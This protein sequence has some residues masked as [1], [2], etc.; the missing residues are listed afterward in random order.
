[1]NSSY[2]SNIIQRMGGERGFDFLVT[3]YSEN[4]HDDASLDQ[5]FGKFDLNTLTCIQKEL[6]LMSFLEPCEETWP[7]K[8]RAMLRNDRM[9]LDRSIFPVLEE[10]F[11]DAL[12]DCFIEGLDFELCKAYFSE[13]HI[14]FKECGAVSKYRDNLIERMGGEAAFEFLVLSYCERLEDD[15][16]LHRYFKDLKLQR[17]TLLHKELILMAVLRPNAENDFEALA[18]RVA[19]TFSPLFALGM[20]EGHFE[21]MESHFSAAVYECLSQADVIQSCLRLFSNLVTFFQ[22]NSLLGNSDN[23][24]NDDEEENEESEDDSDEDEEEDI[25][26]VTSCDSEDDSIHS[27][28]PPM[29][30]PKIVGLSQSDR[31]SESV[32]IRSVES[33]TIRS[34][35]SR[36]LTPGKTSYVSR[37]IQEA[38]E[39][40]ERSSRS[41]PIHTLQHKKNEGASNVS[42]RIQYVSDRCDPLKQSDRTLETVS[43]TSEGAKAG[44]LSPTVLSK[45]SKGQPKMLFSWKS[46]FTGRK[47]TVRKH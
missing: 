20:N 19:S 16:R 12:E 17:M 13:L 42:K 40:T 11:V 23:D 35:E 38:L 32:S 24:E 15:Q 36:T 1:M 34:V 29:P 33:S 7:R 31:S 46:P 10:H 2:R 4:I 28:L 5:F 6:L 8:K 21:I 18:R 22:D 14:L 41:I 37:R 27:L 3:A 39:K 43:V 45:R 25:H 26:S 47:K 30:Y 9:G 44:I